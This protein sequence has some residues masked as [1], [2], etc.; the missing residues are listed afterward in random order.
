MRLLRYARPNLR[1][2]PQSL[3]WDCCN[4]S[5][6][7]MFNHICLKNRKAR[8]VNNGESVDNAVVTEM[9]WR[10]ADFDDIGDHSTCRLE[11]ACSQPTE[12]STHKN[13]LSSHP[14]RQRSLAGTDVLFP[15][16]CRLAKQPMHIISST[17]PGNIFGTDFQSHQDDLRVV[18]GSLRMSRGSGWHVERREFRLSKETLAFEAVDPA[19]L[20]PRW[21]AYTRVP[22]HGSSGVAFLLHSCTSST[23]DQE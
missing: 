17:I 15:I 3:G 22:N 12:I 10:S 6:R 14:L 4:T 7:H 16:S 18:S 20:L 23:V 21:P 13:S 9:K 11:P 2:I 1:Y 5:C 8:Y 19:G